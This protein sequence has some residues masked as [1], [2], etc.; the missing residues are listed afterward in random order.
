MLVYVYPLC[1]VGLIKM[2]ILNTVICYVVVFHILLRTG[3]YIYIYNKNSIINVHACN[4]IAYKIIEAL[5]SFL[6]Q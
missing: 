1:V 2:I 3:K 4:C 5:E 6:T